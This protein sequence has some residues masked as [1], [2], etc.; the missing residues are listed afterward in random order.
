VNDRNQ[1]LEPYCLGEASFPVLKK[2]APFI[3]YELERQDLV[4]KIRS[5]MV[6]TPE[7]WE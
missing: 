2:N 4:D 1:W 6:Y 7:L 5:I 3:A